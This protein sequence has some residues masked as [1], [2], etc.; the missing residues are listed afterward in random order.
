MVARFRDASGKEIAIWSRR[1]FCIVA[2]LRYLLSSRL[3]RITARCSTPLA[4]WDLRI[5][6]KEFYRVEFHQAVCSPL[7]SGLY[8]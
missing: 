3:G 4:E 1:K 7:A 8:R 6:G 5:G 2:P